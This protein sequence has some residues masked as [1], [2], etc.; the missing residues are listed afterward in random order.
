[1]KDLALKTG[2]ALRERGLKV[3]T[4]E[5]CTGGWIARELTSVA[6]SSSWFDCGFVSY[7]DTAK[8]RMLGVDAAALA[9]HGAVS[10]PVVS[11]MA[12]G[13]LHN[14]EADI[15]VAVCG[16]AGPDGALGGKP[17]GTMW[18]AWAVAGQPTVTCLSYFSGEREAVR[19]QAVQQALDGIMAYLPR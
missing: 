7:S 11:Q 2:K 17:V 19:E 10:E 15:A 9:S 18:F 16:L 13:A 8:Q 1:M 14:S 6:G 4:A 3:A 12:E 5:S